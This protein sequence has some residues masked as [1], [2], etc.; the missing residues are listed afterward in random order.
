MLSGL[1]LA[2]ALQ[3]AVNLKGVGRAELARHFGVQP[4][5]INGW[6]KTGR[7]HKRHIDRLVRYFSD[8]VDPG[9]W[10]ISAINHP[11]GLSHRLKELRGRESQSRA[12]RRC[13]ISQP[14]WS[15]LERGETVE[16][17]LLPKIAAAYN[18]SLNWLA[19]GASKS[20]DHLGGESRDHL[21]IRQRVDQHPVLKQLVMTS[22]KI[23][24]RDADR[25]RNL[26]QTM[27]RIVQLIDR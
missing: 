24:E 5:S 16:T 9:H 17:A 21:R 20:H 15:K 13:G 22:L 8:V 18:V 10:G 6:I 12:A 23:C 4:P 26:C 25:G 14:M 27:L 11:M 3:Q 19:Y 1:E 7:I 2:R